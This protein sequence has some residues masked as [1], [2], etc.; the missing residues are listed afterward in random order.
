M[1]FA[2]ALTQQPAWVGWWL[3]WLLIGAFLLPVVLLIWRQSRLAGI[4]SLLASVLAGVLINLMYV[5]MG[6]IKL[7]GLP[8]I[9]LWVPLLFYLNAQQKRVDMPSWPRRIIHV[10]MATLLISLAFDTI[11][12]MQYLLGDR[13]ATALAL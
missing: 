5:Q 10:V 12:T 3:N 2:E 7:L 8:H 11:S 6:Y 9:L 4:L 13:T 1:N